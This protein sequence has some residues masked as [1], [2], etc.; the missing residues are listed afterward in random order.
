MLR[1]PIGVRVR[2]RHRTTRVR[3]GLVPGRIRLDRGRRSPVRARGP[4]P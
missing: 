4:G 3:L 2:Y 1:R